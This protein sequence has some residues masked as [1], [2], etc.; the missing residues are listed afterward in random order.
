MSLYDHLDELRARLMRALLV[1]CA[2]FAA[3]YFLA[4]PILAVLRAPLF[5]V[6][7][8]DQHKLYYTNLFENFFVHLK[9]AGYAS[10]FFLSP[11]YFWE[12]WGFIAPGL[13]PRERKWV[14]P[15]IL[16]ATVF[17]LAGAAFA[18]FVLFTAAFKFFI[19][20]GNLGTDVPLLTMDAYYSTCLKLM[21]L[22]GAAFEL[23]VMI[24]LLGLLG[25]VDADALRAQRKTAIVGITFASAAFAPPDV[26]SMIILMAPLVLM[27]EGAIF[28][29]AVIG[30]K[31]Q[32]AAKP[33]SEIEPTS[34]DGRSQA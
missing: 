9:I 8:P 5:A 23:P 10:L 28:A 16:V 7:P 18:Y 22:F 26:V 4:D 6:L 30:R 33:A 31:R 19:T 32:A 34:F 29:V 17:F 11:Y 2:G 3:F 13:Y 21:L 20:Y 1:F 27:Y 12:V 24:V 15:F 14:M 25:V